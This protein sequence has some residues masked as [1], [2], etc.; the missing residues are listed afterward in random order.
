MID[1]VARVGDAFEFDDIESEELIVEGVK[2]RVATPRMLYR[3]K[4]DT[5]R[6]QD[7][8][9]A[10]NLRS[11]FKLKEGLVPVR[12]MQDIAEAV[13]PPAAP[14]RAANLR[15]AFELSE[16]CMRLGPR[17]RLRGVLRYRSI[18]D[19]SDRGPRETGEQSSL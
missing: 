7:H 10:E 15:S 17:D 6:P 3:M 12:K 5:V 4:R 8:L 1:L 11:R 16:I 2:V 14:L 13:T 9:D 18:A 19:A